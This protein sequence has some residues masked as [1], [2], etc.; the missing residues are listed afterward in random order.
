MSFSGKERSNWERVKAGLDAARVQY[1]TPKKDQRRQETGWVSWRWE[2]RESPE[3][4]RFGEK[5]F[6]YNI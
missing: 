5:E 3:G 4:C 6:P 1:L 2:D